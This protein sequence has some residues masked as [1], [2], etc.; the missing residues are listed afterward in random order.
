MIT[1]LLVPAAERADLPETLEAT[2]DYVILTDA[3]RARPLA[4]QLGGGAGGSR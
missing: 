2:A 3:A 4:E 1:V